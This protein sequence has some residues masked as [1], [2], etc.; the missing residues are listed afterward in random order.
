MEGLQ[1]I[2]S[3][4][5]CAA[6]CAGHAQPENKIL[7]LET[8]G[9]KFFGRGLRAPHLKMIAPLRVALPA[10]ASKTSGISEALDPSIARAQHCSCPLSLAAAADC[11]VKCG[12]RA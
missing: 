12:E 10:L 3:L 8:Q 6:A 2:R 9:A 5:G 7:A 1:S 11:R 4:Q